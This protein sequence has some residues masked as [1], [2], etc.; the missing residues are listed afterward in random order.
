MIIRSQLPARATRL[1]NRSR[2]GTQTPTG[3]SDSPRSLDS[4]SSRRTPC[5]SQPFREVSTS[6]EDM[7]VLDKSLRNS[8][9][10]DV[11]FF[12]KQLVRLRRLL[13]EV[14]FFLS[15]FFVFVQCFII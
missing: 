11:V 15:F 10:Q 13:Q 4:I 5:R 2:L 3:G 9:L 12:K 8:M 7:L 6:P 1:L 14:S